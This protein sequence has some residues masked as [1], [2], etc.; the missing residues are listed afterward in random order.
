MVHDRTRYI[1]IT[2]LKSLFLIGIV[3]NLMFLPVFELIPRPLDENSLSALTYESDGIDRFIPAAIYD[4]YQPEK[5]LI[6]Q[7]VMDQLELDVDEL[8]DLARLDS[9]QVISLNQEAELTLP[10]AEAIVEYVEYPI[11]EKMSVV[12]LLTS[13][14]AGVATIGVVDQGNVIAF[15]PIENE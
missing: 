14:E 15:F 5:I 11:D 4:H 12:F 13:P 10:D 9:V 8:H 3:A 6:S 7:E 2:I 1:R